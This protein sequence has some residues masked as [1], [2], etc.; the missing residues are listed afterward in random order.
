MYYH[1]QKPK[2]KA[3]TIPNVGKDVE[4]LELSDEDYKIKQS[5]WKSV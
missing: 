3:L 5:L 1:H 4:K 2:L